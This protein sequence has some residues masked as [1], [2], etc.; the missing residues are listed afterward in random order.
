M[1]IVKKTNEKPHRSKLLASPLASA[2]MADSGTV[3]QEV[4]ALLQEKS[5]SRMIR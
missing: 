5:L 4:F 3:I 1:T 2:E